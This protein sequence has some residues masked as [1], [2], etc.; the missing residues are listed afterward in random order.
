LQVQDG[1]DFSSSGNKELRITL[2]LD[3]AVNS[4]SEDMWGIAIGDLP[5]S[6]PEALQVINITS[7]LVAGATGPL[8]SSPGAARVDIGKVITLEEA[9]LKERERERGVLLYFE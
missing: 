3:P 2:S 6:V 7:G 5:G 1:A 9:P 8:S 4:G